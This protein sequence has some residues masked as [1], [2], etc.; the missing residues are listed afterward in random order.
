MCVSTDFR[1]DVFQSEVGEWSR[2]HFKD[3]A[4]DKLLGMIEEAGELIEAIDKYTSL[5]SRWDEVVDDIKDSFGDIMVF[6]ADYCTVRGWDLKALNLEGVKGSLVEMEDADEPAKHATI[7][8]YL[9]DMTKAL[10]RICHGQLK[11]NQGIRGSEEDHARHTAAQV[12]RVI[13]CLHS[14]CA[15]FEFDLFF[16][17]NKVWEKVKKRDWSSDRVTAGGHA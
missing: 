8:W 17:I 5:N 15:V 11:T 7:D 9:R 2:K 6:M 12:V 1:M 13:R 10:A 16:L 4:S 14:L 3:V